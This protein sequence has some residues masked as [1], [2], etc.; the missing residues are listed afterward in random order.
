MSPLFNLH[1][2]PL[3][4]IELSPGSSCLPS[5]LEMTYTTSTGC[6]PSPMALSL[7]SETQMF[8]FPKIPT[9]ILNLLWCSLQCHQH[10][11]YALAYSEAPRCCFPHSHHP[12]LGS[13]TSSLSPSI[14][15]S[16]TGQCSDQSS[17]AHVLLLPS[18][19]TQAPTLHQWTSI[20][21]SVTDLLPRN[22]SFNG[23]A[24]VF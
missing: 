19:L 16:P 17:E 2:C 15:V 1:Q 12:R 7:A 23:L 6:Q 10:R 4:F 9:L 11:C 20:K 13:I 3:S 21:R 24:T 14:S 22:I 5:C 18:T 8:W